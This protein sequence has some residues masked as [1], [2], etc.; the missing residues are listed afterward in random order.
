MEKINLFSHYH[1]SPACPLPLK[2]IIFYTIRKQLLVI[3]FLSFILSCNAHAFILIFYQQ[4]EPLINEISYQSIIIY[5][6]ENEQIGLIPQ[7]IFK[8]NPRDFCVVVMTPSSPKISKVKQDIFREAEILSKPIQRERGT[9][10]LFD[11][12]FL[13]N[14]DYEEYEDRPEA[15]AGINENK[16]SIAISNTETLSNV[17]LDNIIK[18]LQQNKYKFSASDKDL[19]DFYAKLGW[20]FT[21]ISIDSS[22]QSIVQSSSESNIYNLEPI[23][24][25]YK[26]GSLVYPMRLSSGSNLVKTD[27]LIYILSNNKMAFQGART[28][29]ANRI[30][31]KEAEKILEL[32][33][34][35][36]GIIGQ[37]R[38]LT[39][40]QRIFSIMEMDMDIEIKDAPDNEEFRKVIYYG[41]SPIVDLIP[42]GIVAIIF[43]IFRSRIKRRAILGK[44]H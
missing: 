37:Q 4:D 36:G 11:R 16:N 41:I 13:G 22:Y 25:I 9:K 20:V 44:L 43:L 32:Y 29:Y 39:K 23:M 30:N 3:Y 15:L 21:I 34:N 1:R 33:P 26:S 6:K 14:D 24:L 31:Q 18:W 7:V 5:D 19:I 27:L 2:N 40:L 42:L 35:F 12:D 17:G 8:G 10:C 38:F 28:E